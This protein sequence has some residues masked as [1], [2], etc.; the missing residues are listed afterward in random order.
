MIYLSLIGNNKPIQDRKSYPY[1]IPSITN[2][3]KLEFRKPV[4][5]IMG[6]TDSGKS[7]LAEAIAINAGFNPEG[8]VF[9]YV[10]CARSHSLENQYDTLKNN[11]P[12]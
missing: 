5:F 4:T 11:I 10:K 3:E 7:T 2:L 9:E 6:E 1:N 12:I 8:V